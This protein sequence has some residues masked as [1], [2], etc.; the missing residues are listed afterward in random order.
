M[1]FWKIYH[2][3]IVVYYTR[4]DQKIRGRSL[5]FLHRLINRAG[6]TSNN[7]AT[8]MQLIGYNI[9]DVSCLRALQQSSR[10]RYIAQTDPFYV[11]I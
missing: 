8:H 6:I 4:G 7:I 1:S 9:L 10:R 5:P 3:K 2:K 11:V